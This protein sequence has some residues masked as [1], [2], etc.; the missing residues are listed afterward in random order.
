MS[1]AKQVWS[2]REECPED[3][4][5]QHTRASSRI[6]NKTILQIVWQV[7]ACVIALETL[8]LGALQ[9]QVPLGGSVFFFANVLRCRS[10][11]LR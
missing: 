8:G 6:N 4:V 9:S 11:Q 2:P 7:S 1:G 10:A 3:E 5:L